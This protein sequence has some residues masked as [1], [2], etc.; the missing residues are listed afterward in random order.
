MHVLSFILHHHFDLPSLENTPALLDEV[1]DN[2]A[3]GD[4]PRV[5]V[6]LSSDFAPSW[7]IAPVNGNNYK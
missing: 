5:T 6:I 3:T 1:A 7:L 2:L 4:V